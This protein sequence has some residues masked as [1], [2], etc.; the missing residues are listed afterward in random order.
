V[1]RIRPGRNWRQNPTYV[2]ELRALTGQRARGFTG[3]DILDVVGI[4]VDGVDIAAGVGEGRV[5]VAVDELAQALLRL[6]DGEPAAQATVASGP[7]E[8]LLEARGPDLLLTLV[9]LAPPARV[10]V[11]GL[12]VDARAMRTAVLHAAR[13]LSLDLLS[14][15][16]ALE[17]APLLQR[18]G[19]A[20]AELSRRDSKSPRRWPARAA[21]A[22][23][24]TVS[25]QKKAPTESLRLELPGPTMARLRGGSGIRAAP[26][27]PHLGEGSLSLV[28]KS[29]P[30]L[31]C[32]GPIFLILRN[33]LRDAEGLVDAWETGEREFVLHFGAHEL[34]WDLTAD[35][36]RAPGWRRPLSLSPLRMAALLGLAARAYADEA[37][38][39][40][41]ADELAADLRDSA[42]AL[43]RHCQDLASGDL[44]RAPATISS[45]AAVPPP[46]PTTGPLGPG[47]MRRLIYR[48]AFRAPAPGA[49][50][51]LP[52][53]H[54]PCIVE[55]PDGLAAF[56]E[57]SGDVLWR[58][59]SR[60][61]AVARGAEVFCDAGDSVVRLDAQ[62]G[63]VRWRRRL[64]GA[65]PAQ[66]WAA[67]G[68]VA[69]SLPREGL[70]F[71]TDAGALAFR[72]R[73]A[74]GAPRHLAFAGG[75][76]VAALNGGTLAGLDGS[77]GQVVW[78]R[79]FRAVALR[80]CG[81]RVLALSRGSLALLEAATGRPVWEA[82]APEDATSLT[83]LD[84]AVYMLASGSVHAV[85]LA[86]GAPRA[87]VELPWARHLA[88]EDDG[89][90]VATGE[91]GAACN[92]D[93]AGWA[94]A[95]SGDAPAAPAVLHRGI[96][97]IR[98][99]ETSLHNAS[100]GL[101]LAVLPRC[102]DAA[103]WPDLSCA[104]LL[105]GEV[106]VHRLS[107]HLSL[108]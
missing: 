45:P 105:E 18:L 102:R 89:P 94:I 58:V 41:R 3:A 9:S 8:L 99:P 36:V 24:I 1:I 12:L 50:R 15:S 54:G 108:V 43:D 30:G 98:G 66:L 70:A 78:K 57:Q 91:G 49:L 23:A 26:L 74:G 20:A 56:D 84:P 53:R 77:D 96:V 17:D 103:L 83:P 2:G 95:A 47:R 55:L 6:G 64:R 28:R 86:D 13:G 65:H 80:S 25:Q 7:T 16:P 27:A 69:R 59:E 67:P 71:I 79:R 61:G 32:E 88:A 14:I 52:L 21:E 19:T 10:V 90:L 48:E 38:Q 81:A 33:L 34:R 104:L 93:A 31:Q 29:A 51:L 44:R 106:A 72:A 63:E 35:S 92:L 75:M 42:L 68:G 107:T 40:N 22:K 100:D 76:I 11:A 73:L 5:L 85:S 97:L 60:V 87:S 37:L 82:K 4:E 62:T 39:A 101:P 46:Q